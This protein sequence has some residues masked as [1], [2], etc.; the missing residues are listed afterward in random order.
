[1]YIY[2]YNL[3]NP[4][5]RNLKEDETEGLPGLCHKQ[6]LM[7]IFTGKKLVNV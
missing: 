1:M 2:I 5:K 3:R 7:V 6:C 4:W